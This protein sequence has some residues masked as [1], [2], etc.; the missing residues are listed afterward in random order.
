VTVRDI[1]QWFAK[2][3]SSPLAPLPSPR[4]G[5]GWYPI[6][7]EPFTGAWQQNQELV[8]GDVLA[9]GP[10]FACITLIAQTISK[11]ALRLME[12][13]PGTGIWREITNPAY[14]PVLRKPNR[15]QTRIKFLEQWITSK[16]IWGNTYVL[17]ERDNRGVVTGLYV[18]NPQ[19]CR[20][21]VAPDGAVYYSIDAD[22]LA[23]LSIATVVP[24]SEIIHDPMVCLYH[25]L[26]GVSPIYA[27]GMAAMQ[28][29]AMQ[30]S[31]AALF[32]NGGQPPGVITAPGVITVEQ[33]AALQNDWNARKAGSIAI[34][35][36]GMQ[37][38][39][40]AMNAVD[41]ELIKQLQWTGEDVARCFHVPS[42]MIEIGTTPP[43][44]NYGP[45]LQMFYADAL[46]PLMA[47]LEASYEEGVGIL[48]PVNGT[49]YGVS[50]D[51]NDLLLMDHETRAK[52][53]GEA[54][55]RGVLSPNE[56]RQDYFGKAPV[57][58]GETPFM[59]EQNWP[60]ALLAQR[61]LPTRVPTAPTPI[62]PAAVTKDLDP[63]VLRAK[64]EA[65][66]GLAA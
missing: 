65:A 3:F 57:E 6:I 35:S 50:F 58:G 22:L 18:L 14:S 24:A 43:Y 27:C 44:G 45:L 30:Q 10:V 5:R 7:R 33:V 23:E 36:N 4:A 8:V 49:Q 1:G 32:A 54:V 39:P 47:N 37:Y 63:A 59:Q 20:P 41:A 40:L 15:Y 48:L 64:L 29:L 9:Y 19:R 51:V 26:C 16:L 38:E 25:P 42:F 17:K 2:A 52:V 46:Q 55:Q 62:S 53:A 21:L 61:E 11:L 34:L 60:V 66:L 12:Q 13:D 56:G 28:G 31:S